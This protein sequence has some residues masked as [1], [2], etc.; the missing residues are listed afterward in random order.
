[1]SVEGSLGALISQFSTLPPM[2]SLTVD[3]GRCVASSQQQALSVQ[4]VGKANLVFDRVTPE[5]GSLGIGLRR[6]GRRAGTGFGSVDY[7]RISTGVTFM[8]RGSNLDVGLGFEL[9]LGFLTFKGSGLAVS[10]DAYLFEPT[11][12]TGPE[13][14][15][16]VGLGYVHSPVTGL[17]ASV[18]RVRTVPVH[19]D[20]N[21]STGCPH[22]SAYREA[23]ARER[24]NA[25][26]TCNAQDVAACEVSRARVLALSSGL[27]A[28]EYGENVPAPSEVNDAPSP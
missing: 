16:A 13:T 1:V 17:R 19:R 24:K 7:E 23:L 21:G 18:P 14:V 5:F 8:S 22:L 20:S 4:A 15:F 27:T 12:M 6:T 10:L 28:C 26:T 11:N 3:Y 9:A 25:V 2:M